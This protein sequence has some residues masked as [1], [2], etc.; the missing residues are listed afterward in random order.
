MGILDFMKMLLLAPIE[1]GYVWLTVAAV[2]LVGMSWILAWFV[3]FF[4]AKYAREWRKL[5]STH[6]RLKISWAWGW[7]AVALVLL[8]N[9]FQL[10]YRD[11]VSSLLAA[12]P[13]LV[14]VPLALILASML[15]HSVR[16]EVKR[17]QQI[18]QGR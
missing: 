4:H 14:A 2:V 15:R 18:V 8:L 11:R 10:V 12:A 13:Y 6:S 9:L 16:A 17:Y 5:L 7:C 1:L 3:A